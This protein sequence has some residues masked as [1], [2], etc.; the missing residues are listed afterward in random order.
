MAIPDKGVITLAYGKPKYINMA[1]N[2]ARSLRLHSKHI[3]CA[4]VTDNPNDTELQKLFHIVIPFKPEY[5]SNVRQKLYLNSYSPY[6][7]TIFIDSDSII[8]R[9][10]DFIFEAFEGR[11]FSL[12]GYRYLS[13]GD[14]DNLINVDLVLTHFCLDRLPKF[15][16]GLYYFDKSDIANSVF[17]TAQNILLDWKKLGFSE[18]RG[19]GPG[20]EPIIAISMA[21]NNQSMFQDSGNMM[22]TPIGL[23]GSLDVDVLTGKSTF[24]KY[25]KF[26]SPAVVHFA[27]DWV[28]HPVYS[29]EAIKLKIL[30]AQNHDQI[31]WNIFQKIQLYFF[32][33]LAFLPY[34]GKQLLKRSKSVT[35]HIFQQ[36]FFL[37]NC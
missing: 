3:S 26:V 20:D 8:V 22:R 19:D 12:A 6:K 23:K 7:K 10:I 5:G 34:T 32:Y 29:R 13:Y 18:F 2:L 24:K 9:N 15:N 36:L 14:Q 25:D 4:I 35:K 27:G 21:L 28:K 31:N 37:N 1:K 30:T 16:G 11:S 17:K 33:Q